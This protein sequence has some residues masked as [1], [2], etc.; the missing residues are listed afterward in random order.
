MA[1]H[2]ASAVRRIVATLTVLLAVTTAFAAG[3]LVSDARRGEKPQLHL[4]AAGLNSGLSCERLRQWYVA[5]GLDRVTAWG[6]QGPALRAYAVPQAAAPGIAED[7]IGSAP[8]SSL[9]T[10]TG[11]GTGTNVQETGVDEPD[12]ADQRRLPRDRRRQRAGVAPTRRH[13]AGPDRRPAAAAG[14]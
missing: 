12:I 5:H 13:P 7:S 2:L 4:A 6:W 14:R 1:M 10:A 3:F 8:S 9:D 11:S